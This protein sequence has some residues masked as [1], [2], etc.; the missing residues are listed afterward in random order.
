[1]AFVLIFVSLTEF[2]TNLEYFSQ[3]LTELL[4]LQRIRLLS[5]LYLPALCITVSC[6]AEPLSARAGVVPNSAPLP[7]CA[8]LVLV[9]L[10][11]GVGEGLGLGVGLG[12][13]LGNQAATSRGCIIWQGA[14]FGTTPARADKGSAPCSPNE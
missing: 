12:L 5:S 8:P 1:M 4:I 2:F 14:E 10:G 3:D 13:G 11:V 6:D 7:D 9:G